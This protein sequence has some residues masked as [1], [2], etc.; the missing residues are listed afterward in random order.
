M[1]P[2]SAALF[3]SGVCTPPR[4]AVSR[5][6]QFPGPTEQ[7]LQILDAAT[8]GLVNNK[9]YDANG[10]P[11]KDTLALHQVG[12][13]WGASDGRQGAGAVRLLPQSACHRTCAQC[14][15]ANHRPVH[16]L[17]A[18]AQGLHCEASNHSLLFTNNDEL[19]PDFK[20]APDGITVQTLQGACSL[21]PCLWRSSVHTCKTIAR[22]VAAAVAA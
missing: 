10:I 21:T 15:D 7:A 4:L 22:A 18:Y 9:T 17:L 12:T 8:P 1:R 16:Q 5:T 6:W 14:P 2:P 19:P 20:P 11:L 3:A 13:A